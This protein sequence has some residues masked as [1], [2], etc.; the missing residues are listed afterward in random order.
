MSQIF[1]PTL[2][3]KDTAGHFRLGTVILTI[4]PEEISISKVQNNDEKTPLRSRFPMF[5][6][7]GHARTDVSISWKALL[8]YTPDGQVDYSEWEDVQQVLA[9]FVAAPFVEVENS[10]LRQILVAQD[11]SYVLTDRMAFAMRQLRVDTLPDIVDGLQVSLTMSWFNYRPYSRNFAFVGDDGGGTDAYLSGAF[12]EYLDS[13]INQ[14]LN[15][16]LARK[17]YPYLQPWQTQDPGSLTFN[18]RRYVAVPKTPA[19]PQTS[20]PSTQAPVTVS[21]AAAFKAPVSKVKSSKQ[22]VQPP[23]KI[24]EIITRNAKAFGVPPNLCLAISQRE[25]SFN[26]RAKNPTSTASGLFQLLTDTAKGL[27]CADVFSPEENAR[28]GCKY[29]SQLFKMFSGDSQKALT[30]F[31]GGQGNVMKLGVE[32]TWAKFPW[33]PGWIADVTSIYN[34][35]EGS[36][37]P[38]ALATPPAATPFADAKATTEEPAADNQEVVD[39]LTTSDYNYQV[40][41]DTDNATFMYRGDSLT[42][43]DQEHSG[44]DTG[45]F[46]TKLTVVFVNNIVQQPLNSFQYPTAQHIGPAGTMISIAMTGQGD[47]SPET[48]EEPQH[49]SLGTLTAA[50]GMMEDQY[51]RMKGEWRSVAS[52]H[53]MQAMVLE[54]Q[55]LNMLGI[56]GVIPQ[57]MDSHTIPDAAN[58]VEAS[59]VCSQYE[60]VFEQLHPFIVKGTAE[61]N[62]IWKEKVFPGK[63]ADGNQ[64]PSYLDQVPKDDP[65]MAP[66]QKYKADRDAQA[67]WPLYAWMTKLDSK[68]TGV[69]MNI[70]LSDAENTSL[71]S[72]W[73]PP[74]LKTNNTAG[75]W[76]EPDSQMSFTDYVLL[77]ENPDV[78]GDPRMAATKK[79]IMPKVRAAA[80]A[81]SFNPVDQLYDAYLEWLVQNDRP[82]SAA[83]QRLETTDSLHTDLM[84]AVDPK[85]PGAANYNLEHGAYRD[86]GLTRI[87]QKPADYFVDDA[88]SF[89]QEFANYLDQAAKSVAATTD[90]FNQINATTNIDIQSS[91]PA[92]FN[93]KAQK[94]NVAHGTILNGPGL[95]V[96]IPLPGQQTAGPTAGDVKA[97]QNSRATNILSR[98]IIPFNSMNRAFPTF[99]LMFAEEDNSGTF[100][101][102]DDF[103]SYASVLSAE[104]IRYQDKPDQAVIQLTN[105]ANLLSHKIFDNSIEGKFEFDNSPKKGMTSASDGSAIAAPMAAKQF[106]SETR[107]GFNHIGRDMTSGYDK[108]GKKI[109]M[110]YYPLQAGSKLQF[111]IGF[112]NNPDELFPVFSGVVTQIEEGE[113][114]TLIAQGFAI[115][116]TESQPDDLSYNGYG[117]AF[118]GNLLTKEVTGA[119]QALVGLMPG[120]N[121]TVAGGLG[122]MVRGLGRGPAY[123][124]SAVMG[125]AGNAASVISAMLKSSRS[126]HFGHWQVNPVANQLM[127]GFGYAPLFGKVLANIGMQ[128]SATVLRD[129]Y[130]RSPENIYTS[131]TISFDGTVQQGTR[132]DFDMEAP[133]NTISASYYVPKD[134]SVTPWRIIQDVKR[135]YPEYIVKVAPYGFPFGIDATLVFCPPNDVY[136]SRLPLYGEAEK[137][138]SDPKDAPAFKEWWDRN[139]NKLRRIKDSTRVLWASKVLFKVTGIAGVND[140]LAIERLIKLVDAGGGND[141]GQEIF[142]KIMAAGVQTANEFEEYA[143]TGIYSNGGTWMNVVNTVVGETVGLLFKNEN[144]ARAVNLAQQFRDFQRQKDFVLQ[145]K[146][147]GLNSAPRPNDRVQPVRNWHLVTYHNIIHNGIQLNDQIYNAVRI[148]DKTI[149][150]ND[151]V[152][153]FQAHMHVLD[154]DRLIIDPIN[155]VRQ[156]GLE[157]NY[158]QSF[159]KEELGKMYRGELVLTGIPEMNPH[160]IIV[161]Y[162]PTTGMMG[163]IEAESV[164]HSLDQESGFMTI[165]KPRAVV[166][167]NE[168]F[169]AGLGSAMM[170]FFDAA[171]GE[172]KGLVDDFLALSSAEKKTVAFGAA[173]TALGAALAAKIGLGSVTGATSYAVG[174]VAGAEA[175]ATA[176]ASVTAAAATAVSAPVLLTA[177][178]VA[179]AGGYMVMASKRQGLNPMFISPLSRYGQ[180]WVAGVDGWKLTDLHSS[181]KSTWQVFNTYELQPTL[182]GF[183][184]LLG[185][186]ADVGVG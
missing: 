137:A 27:G 165:V 143:H 135:R 175:A 30:G 72:T 127:R 44:T 167:I 95:P 92:L 117:P 17:D 15:N 133:F 111:R 140:D 166:S 33:I 180:P 77:T 179:L 106:A 108:S 93:G 4:P 49:E 97:D 150:C 14:N 91:D 156:P 71:K 159:L 74:L 57:G 6:K 136:L 171:C 45:L 90:Y 173:G 168:A 78:A 176:S 81:G 138:R 35:L 149:A 147:R 118:L 58:L 3:S 134:P 36:P 88:E 2:R 164:I 83:I 145:W 182:R 42:L 158:A 18:W 113:V 51:H 76:V 50:I 144:I 123:G 100:Y 122:L 69:A 181:L 80:A 61:Y 169:T 96:P 177:G 174:A 40:D 64:K 68:P 34:K 37:A 107:G 119:Y 22:P 87:D 56:Y 128:K 184:D 31:T 41:Y 154:V 141:R 161:L 24:R 120:S 185:I 47:Y 9:M 19:T 55:V 10:H 163:P 178:A 67:L 39:L 7:T 13:W 125:D 130:D 82:T 170:T 62:K 152:E 23:D 54:N 84:N 65:L 110:Q 21:G 46:P 98:T 43:S 20:T 172:G 32:G 183:K 53:R 99:K 28:A 73:L 75:K 109:P 60:N 151:G 112:S 8:Q 115:E 16:P 129:G 70:K 121:M 146:A 153:T 160:D 1:A 116:L 105:I 142:D 48:G 132:R 12:Q 5:T 126:V 85:G 63:D 104:I 11:P 102:F 139:K 26:P 38:P 162:D 52:L 114:T 86:L 79:N 101:M 148:Q 186:S 29:I 59:F 103:F 25:S 89:R 131:S 66:L 155:N 157:N 124:G 94:S